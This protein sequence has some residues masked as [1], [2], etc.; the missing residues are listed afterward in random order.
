MPADAYQSIRFEGLEVC[1][2]QCLHVRRAQEEL[3]CLRT[4]RCMSSWST[5]TRAE[6]TGNSMLAA[7]LAWR[8]ETREGVRGRWNGERDA[9]RKTERGGGSSTAPFSSAWTHRCAQRHQRS[10]DIP[11]WLAQY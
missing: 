2:L 6:A 4:S 9:R 11:M 5:S 10:P 3:R 8:Q 7:G 1:V